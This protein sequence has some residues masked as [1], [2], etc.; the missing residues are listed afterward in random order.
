M[1]LQF[2]WQWAAITLSSVLALTGCNSQ[3]RHRVLCVFFTGVDQ[4]TAP[5]PVRP[6]AP[7]T[8]AVLGT[9][10]QTNQPAVYLHQPYAEQK[11][12]ACHL[13]EQSQELRAGGGDLCLECHPKLVGQAKYVH[14]PVK[15]GQCQHC[16]AAHQSTEPYLL[17]RKGQGVCVDCH[18]LA[19]I[20]KV[21]GHAGIGKD[22]CFTCHDPHGS[23][24]KKLLKVP[25]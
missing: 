6:A 15:D 12:A 22:L 1:R 23:E 17:T 5:P 7:G 3:A 16:H 19:K 9:A 4:P 21:K 24:W 11:C 10:A 25:Q 2:Q 18:T 20:E 14:A 13:G 8:N